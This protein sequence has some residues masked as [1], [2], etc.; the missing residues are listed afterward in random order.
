MDWR[1]AEVQFMARKQ[2]RQLAPRGAA[3]KTADKSH[4]TTLTRRASEGAG[5]GRERGKNQLAA[6]PRWR[7]GFVY[8]RRASTEIG[9]LILRIGLHIETETH[10][11]ASAWNCP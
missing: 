8:S 2:A 6:L 9:I 1:I 7:V 5:A 10:H 3:I 11:R 4:T